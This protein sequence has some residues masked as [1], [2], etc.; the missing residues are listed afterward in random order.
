MKLKILTSTVEPDAVLRE[1]E[2][3]L[4]FA[5]ILALTRTA[6]AGRRAL[7]IE[8][9]RVF[10]RPKPSTLSEKSG[11]FRLKPATRRDGDD[12]AEV[13]VKDRPQAKGDPALVYLAHNIR[14][15]PR[16]EKRSEFLLK[17]AGIMPGDTF[18]VPGDGA[19]IDQY[20]NI[21]PGQIQ[22]ILS[23]LG[24]QRDKLQNSRGGDGKRKRRASKDTAQYFVANAF[25][26]RTETKHLFP[27]VYERYGDVSKF[28]IRPVLIFVTKVPTYKARLLFDEIQL[29]EAERQF[30]IQ[31]RFAVEK[32]IGD[33]TIRRARR[34]GFDRFIQ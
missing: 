4:K 12:F 8:S 18:V 33:A 16:V 1:V 13:R 34:L 17:R 26:K 5:E 9:A 21:S 19:R 29:R 15:G 24:A 28:R 3:Q 20:G 11:P 6:E 14:G 7:I 32:V 25:S 30:P 31:L 10:D 27:G 22:Q 23:A 2:K